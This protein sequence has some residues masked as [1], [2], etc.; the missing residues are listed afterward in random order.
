[1]K[2]RIEEIDW[3]RGFATFLVILGHSIIVYPINLHEI[4]WCNVLYEFISSFHMPLFFVISGFCCQ[5]VNRG[6][7][8]LTYSRRRKGSLFHGERSQLLVFCQG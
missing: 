2:E 1:M 4:P 3:L 5:K 8:E 6:G 7:I